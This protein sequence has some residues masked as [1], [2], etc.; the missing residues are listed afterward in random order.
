[1]K[2]WIE[3]E[4]NGREELL[5]AIYE[6]LLPETTRPPSIECR[7]LMGLGSRLVIKIECDRINLLRAVANSYLGMLSTIIH[8]LEEI[9]YG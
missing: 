6:S 2:A 9:G 4:V 3:I 8:S 7:V 5:K 1:M